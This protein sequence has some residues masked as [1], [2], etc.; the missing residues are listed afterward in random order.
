MFVK[1]NKNFFINSNITLKKLNKCINYVV[2]QTGIKKNIINN[3]YKKKKYINIK[4]PKKI[5]RNEIDILIKT[6]IIK[7]YKF[8]NLKKNIIFSWYRKK[9]NLYAIKIKKFK[10]NQIKFFPKTS[11]SNNIIYQNLSNG[12][13]I[14]LP[15]KISNFN[16]SIFINISDVILNLSKKNN[17]KTTIKKYLKKFKFSYSEDQLNSQKI[18]YFLK[19]LNKYQN[20]FIQTSLTHGD[21][22]HEHLFIKNKKL[23]SVIDWEDVG[24]RSIFFDLM[25]FIIPWLVFK[26]YNY[27]KIKNFIIKFTKKYLPKLKKIIINNYEIYLFIFALE[28]YKRIKDNKKIFN[29]HEINNAYKRYDII[30]KDLINLT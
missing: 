5:K 11:C 1:I 2:N 22:K 23:D 25:N 12:Y 9:T 6:N 17:Q 21:F 29:N 4:L 13:P 3:I 15:K 10:L 16:S 27:I 14:K 26:S 8:I 19:V 28:R 24:Q 7:D 30:F 20:N 18:K